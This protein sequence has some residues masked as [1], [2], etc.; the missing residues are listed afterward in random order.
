MDVGNATKVILSAGTLNQCIAGV[1]VV[2]VYLIFFCFEEVSV[3]RV[4]TA[5]R[6][7]GPATFSLYG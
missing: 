2:R 1:G 6:E 4:Y 3:Y 7:T 5:F